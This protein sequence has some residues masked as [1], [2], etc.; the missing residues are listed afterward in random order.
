MSDDQAKGGIPWDRVRQ[1]LP[2]ASGHLL[3]AIQQ[4]YGRDPENP[5]RA[6]DR[7]LKA[8]LAD[9]QQRFERLKGSRA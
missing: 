8:K 2:A 1:G 3:D 7:E 6:I 5:A 9:L 4:A